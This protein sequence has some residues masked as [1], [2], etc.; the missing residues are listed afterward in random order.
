LGQHVDDKIANQLINIMMYL[1]VEDKSKD[2]Y[3]Y[4]NSLGGVVLA[5]IFV[6]DVM[7]FVVPDVHT[8]CMGLAASMG[9]FI[10][11]GGKITKRITLPLVLCQCFFLLYQGRNVY[12]EREV[13]VA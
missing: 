9:S 13:L 3:L 5:G 12:I 1:N 11:T 8:I 2:M 6:H 4:I 10:L 7:Q